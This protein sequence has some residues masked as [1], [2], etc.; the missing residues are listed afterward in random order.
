VDVSHLWENRQEQ[1]N[2]FSGTSDRSAFREVWMDMTREHIF[3]SKQTGC[4]GLEAKLA[5][6]AGEGMKRRASSKRCVSLAE[7]DEKRPLR[8]KNGPCQRSKQGLIF[9]VQL[10][11]D[12]S[13]RSTP[14]RQVE[15]G[16]ERPFGADW[17]VSL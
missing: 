2:D 8:P 17:P 6:S 4:C 15:I 12:E 7:G 3:T 16:I 9:T 14:N 10:N 11:V 13:K 5:I 1:R